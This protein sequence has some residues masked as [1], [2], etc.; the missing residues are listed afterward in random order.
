MIEGVRDSKMLSAGQ[1]LRV[2]DRIFAR[3]DA[4]ALGAASVAEVERVNPRVAE[5]LALRR[6]LRR[7]GAVDHVL[8]DGLRHK[9]TD[10]GP[11]TTIVDGVASSYLIAFAVVGAVVVP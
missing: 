7:I 6:A 5:I 9:P 8:V 1:R 11:Y 2:F 10:F 4:V 3:S